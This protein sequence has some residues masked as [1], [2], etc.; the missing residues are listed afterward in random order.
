V[1]DVET[2]RHRRA[3]LLDAETVGVLGYPGPRNL[4][5][6]SPYIDG[7]LLLAELVKKGLRVIAFARVCVRGRCMICSCSNA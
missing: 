5:M 6:A 1:H 3:G 7:A 4:L 2:L